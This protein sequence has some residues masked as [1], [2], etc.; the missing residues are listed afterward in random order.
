[1]LARCIPLC[2]VEAPVP[3]DY[4]TKVA[5]VIG[6]I[7]EFEDR[8]ESFPIEFPHD[9]QAVTV[10]LRKARSTHQILDAFAALIEAV[11]DDRDAQDRY[12]TLEERTGFCETFQSLQRRATQI[13]QA[14]DEVLE[15][16]VLPDLV[17]QASW[18]LARR[19]R[20]PPVLLGAIPEARGPVSRL[21]RH[22]RR[23]PRGH[24]R[25]PSRSARGSLTRRSGDDDPEHDRRVQDGDRVPHHHRRRHL[26]PRGA[27]RRR[28][29]DGFGAQ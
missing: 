24:R 27:D 22:A 28:G 4:S 9:L 1:M 13:A 26:D 14:L 5:F 11:L 25:R 15:D 20:R 23:A 17:A 10:R 12:A 18:R 6:V 2:T 8:G 29:P 21:V 7:G 19:K 3:A 16:G